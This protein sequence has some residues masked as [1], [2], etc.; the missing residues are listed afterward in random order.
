MLFL[1]HFNLCSIACPDCIDLDNNFE[2]T[3]KFDWH[4]IGEES[5]CKPPKEIQPA[6]SV[7]GQWD[8]KSYDNDYVW[9]SN[10]LYL[11]GN[12]KNAKKLSYYYGTFTCPNCGK[13]SIVMDLAKRTMIQNMESDL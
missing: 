8:Q 4:I 13:T 6:P 1:G 7:I 3:Y 11:L 9:L 5:V 10:L 2:M 12:D